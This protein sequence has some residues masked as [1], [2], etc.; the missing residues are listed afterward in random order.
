MAA[1]GRKRLLQLVTRFGVLLLTRCPF[2]FCFSQLMLYA[3]RAEAKRKPDIS[4]PY[5][6]IDLAVAVV[7]AS[8]M[9]F[10][11]KR[12]WFALGSALQ[13]AISTYVGHI[14][15]H[16]YYGDWLK[17]R[18]YSRIIAV[19]GGFLVLASGAGEIYRQKP[20]SRSL[21]STGQVFL[22][23]Y[24]ICVAY[25]LQHSKDDRLA[26]LDFIPGGEPALQI[27]FVLYGV[28]ALSF[29]SGYYVRSTSQVLAVLLPFSLLL[30]D[31]NLGY[32]HSSRKVEFWNQMRLIGQ[33]VGIF[34]AV[35][36]LATDG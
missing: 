2:W 36:I 15:G 14:G 8:F 7:C 16:V 1:S 18:M 6:Y 21:Q 10:G 31:G 33:N 20:R 12:R 5:L 32:W 25:T 28:L 3:E 27:L 19:I 9:S 11:V 26:Y 34:G 30:I 4:V 29:L 22:G 35:V 13:L 24:L 17:V 23:I